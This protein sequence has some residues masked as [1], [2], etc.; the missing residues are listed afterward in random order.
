VCGRSTQVQDN[1]RTRVG[2]PIH[3][4]FISQQFKS[5]EIRQRTTATDTCV[6]I[7]YVPQEQVH[8][9]ANNRIHIVCNWKC[10]ATFDRLLTSKALAFQQRRIVEEETS[11]REFSSCVD[12][13]LFE[14][15]C[16]LNFNHPT[17]RTI[18]R[19]RSATRSTRTCKYQPNWRSAS[20]CLS[21]YIPTHT[22]LRLS[23]GTA[24]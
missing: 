5:I 10:G 6:C 3:Y 21:S 23:C 22:E 18:V 4:K 8:V 16:S 1:E 11:S 9:R 13:I 14:L 15:V 19:H 12:C 7:T 20:A 17:F 2:H 24:V